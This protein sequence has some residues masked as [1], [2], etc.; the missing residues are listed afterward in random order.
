MRWA[1][2]W[3][4]GSRFRLPIE[5]LY[6]WL[7]AAHWGKTPGSFSTLDGVAVPYFPVLF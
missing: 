2:A 4:A 3:F 1:A 7:L 5:I 6:I